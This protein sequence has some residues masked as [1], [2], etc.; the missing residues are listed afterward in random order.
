VR[1]CDSSAIITFIMLPNR[2]DYCDMKMKE[3][4]IKG[5]GYSNSTGNRR[6]FNAFR[7]ME[8][9][10]TGKGK[11]SASTESAQPE[12]WLEFMGNKIRV[13]DEDGGMVKEED[14]PHV[15]GATLKFVGFEGDVQYADI[16]VCLAL[17]HSFP[18]AALTQRAESFA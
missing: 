1:G 2:K 14:V 4:G 10:K 12:V 5:T 8:K 15:N 9:A 6:G 7:D 11:S 18:P 13:Y 17:H 16:K 3:K